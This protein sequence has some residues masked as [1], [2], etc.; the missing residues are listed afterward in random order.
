MVSKCQYENAIDFYFYVHDNGIQISPHIH[1]IPVKKKDQKTTFYSLDLSKQYLAILF[2]S[3]AAFG[4]IAP[5]IFRI[6]WLSNI[7]T[8]SV[9]YEVYS[10]T[11]SCTLNLIARFFCLYISTR[12]ILYNCLLRKFTH[13][14]LQFKRNF[15]ISQN[16]L[17]HFEV[18]NYSYHKYGNPIVF[19]LTRHC[20]MKSKILTR[21]GVQS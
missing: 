18:Q 9:P 3:F 16:S 8:L 13:S 19:V 20:Y 6:I 11:A 2:R 21:L 7:S 5:K 1:I 15:D 14:Q 12:R 17:S 10:R 4:L